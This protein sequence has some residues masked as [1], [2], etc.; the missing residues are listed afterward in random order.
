MILIDLPFRFFT[1]SG[2]IT[3]LQSSIPIFPTRLRAYL[4]L[5]TKTSLDTNIS[6]RTR[7][8]HCTLSSPRSHMLQVRKTL[9][10]RRKR[11][12]LLN[13]TVFLA[14]LLTAHGAPQLAISQDVWQ[15]ILV[16]SS[17]T[18]GFENSLAETWDGEATHQRQCKSIPAHIVYIFSFSFLLHIF[19]KASEKLFPSFFFLYV[20]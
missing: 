3:S 1:H 2:I 12:P 15:A 13:Y 10:R 19:K 6:F 4:L 7:D 17:V 20:I 14:G 9:F 11:K 8:D 18:Y 16:G 5:V